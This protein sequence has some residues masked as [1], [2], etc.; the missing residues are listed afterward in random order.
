M[1]GGGWVGW[2]GRRAIPLGAC[3]GGGVQPA[4]HGRR[5]QWR[6][7]CHEEVRCAPADPPVWYG[8]MNMSPR[9]H[10]GPSGAGTS[11][12]MNPLTHCSSP[13]APICNSQ[14]ARGA[15]GCGGRRGGGERGPAHALPLARGAA[16]RQQGACQA[17]PGGRLRRAR[18][19]CN[20]SQD[21]EGARRCGAHAGYLDLLFLK[22]TSCFNSSYPLTLRTYWSGLRV[23]S[24]PEM[25]KVTEGMVGRA[26]QSTTAA[27]GAQQEGSTHK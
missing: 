21:A 24:L 25:V 22:Q 11:N 17:A 23:K 2:G 8:P 4:G 18:P 20:A 1:G 15:S 16:G 13:A 9:I 12:P 3:S 5:Q 6:G 14:R 19:C 7:S 10:S 27:G 26:L